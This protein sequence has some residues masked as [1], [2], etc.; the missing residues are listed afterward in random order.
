VINVG[1]SDA[2]KS[3][4]SYYRRNKTLPSLC[5]WGEEYQV[6]AKNVVLEFHHCLSAI[7][8]KK[9]LTTAHQA[10]LQVGTMIVDGEVHVTPFHPLVLAYYSELS[11]RAM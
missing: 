7:E 9:Y 6:L 3:L 8:P 10:L 4:Y 11:A 5:G 1:L 2:F